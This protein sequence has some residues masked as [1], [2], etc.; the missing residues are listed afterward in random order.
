MLRKPLVWFNSCVSLAVCPHG[1]VILK[2]T[3]KCHFVWYWRT[4]LEVF[5]MCQGL[6][7]INT[8][9]AV[10]PRMCQ[11]KLILHPTNLLEVAELNPVKIN[12]VFFY[13]NFNRFWINPPPY[14]ICYKQMPP[15][16]A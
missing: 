3:V 9:M 7:W 14:Y 15:M 11:I 10:A 12:R 16:S 1:I 2:G 5:F 8:C 6:E 4:T 13:V